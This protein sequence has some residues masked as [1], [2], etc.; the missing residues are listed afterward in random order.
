[1]GMFDELKNKAMDMAGDN[2]DKVE[3]LTDKVLDAAADAANAAT[4]GKFADQIDSVKE[5]A[6]GA[7][8][9]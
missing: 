4:G 2:L 6:D 9:E 1:M 7:I 3:G 8:G 5:Q